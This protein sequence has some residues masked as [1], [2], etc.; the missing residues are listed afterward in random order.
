MPT[1]LIHLDGR[2]TPR[3]QSKRIRRAVTYWAVLCVF[4]GTVYALRVAQLA[5][6]L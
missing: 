2:P 4:V 5:G 3:M 6:V 1:P